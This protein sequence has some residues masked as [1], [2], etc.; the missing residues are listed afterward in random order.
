MPIYLYYI[1]HYSMSAII[2]QMLKTCNISNFESFYYLI[3][4][5][6][7]LIITIVL[8]TILTKKNI[9][10]KFKTR[11]T[12]ELNKRITLTDQIED[13]K[14]QNRKLK[15]LTDEALQKSTIQKEEHKILLDEIK[16]SQ[17][18]ILEMY[19]NVKESEKQYRI[20]AESSQDMIVL[21]D[22][23]VKITYTNKAFQDNFKI[24]NEINAKE[25]LR[26]F[27]EEYQKKLLDNFNLRK[28]GNKNKT[29]YELEVTM[30][31]GEKKPVEVSSN[32]II[33]NGHFS[34]VL[35]VI[36]NIED[37]INNEIE[38]L[39]KNKKLIENNEIQKHL[40]NEL[41]KAKNK[42]EES[43][44]LKTSFLANMSHEVRT[45]M[46]GIIGFVSLLDKDGLSREKQKQYIKIIQNS[47]EQLLAIISDI[48]DFSKIES[49]ELTLSYINFDLSAFLEEIRQDA[50][51]IKEK[52]EKERIDITI[53]NKTP[54]KTEIYF[55]KTRLKQTLHNI[56]DNAIKFTDSGKVTISVKLEENNLLFSVKDTGMGISQKNL[57]IIFERFIQVENSLRR[58]H[59]GT[60]LGLS[61]CKGIIN[62]GGGKIW[63]ESEENIGTAVFFTIP[64]LQPH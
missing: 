46:N 16:I 64:L 18:E 11:F 33:E 34:G 51:T 36:R 52:K 42:A 50:I 27:S 55:D 31:N 45:P 61:I 5:L 62:I 60:G 24:S 35:L 13:L 22:K 15:E 59:G 48:I 3:I 23:D 9:T 1:I 21:V 17:E 8:S 44:R 43:D 20:L 14:N 6:I 38:L 40:I 29:I 53:K 57:K 58:V 54:N 19:K 2:L 28:L 4:L 37:R 25:L 63:I 26:H 32:P 7:V 49:N 10:F 47:T 12:K 39:S 56:I 41:N 30:P